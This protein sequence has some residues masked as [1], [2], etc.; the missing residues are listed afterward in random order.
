[1]G[2]GQAITGLVLGIASIII[3]I[4]IM[5][6]TADTIND[7]VD[8]INS[9]TSQTNE[10]NSKKA[11]AKSIII[12]ETVTEK[13]WEITVK[14]TNFKQDVIPSNPD[15]FY[16]HYQVKDTDNIYMYVVLTA[17][18]ISTLALDADKVA[19]V[20]FKYDNKYEYN[21]FSAVEKKGGG[22]FTYTNITRIDPLTAETLYYLVEVPKTIADE[23]DT[24]VEAEITIN[25]NIYNLKIR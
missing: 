21:A 13:D 22:T 19:K 23:T 4:S 17:K 6:G 7:A 2:I 3:M 15:S 18:N 12:G 14:E 24:P 1:M 10:K 20:K 25:N 16:T 11:N 9:N 5:G 8:K